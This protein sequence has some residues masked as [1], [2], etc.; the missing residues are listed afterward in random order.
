MKRWLRLV[1]LLVILAG[2][3]FGAQQWIARRPAAQVQS[4][5]APARPAPAVRTAVVDP[6]QLI[7]EDIFPADVRASAT[8][9]ITS[10]IAGR[11]GAVLIKEGSVVGAGSLLA[12]IEDPEMVLAVKQAE[13]AVAV[14]RA[15][16][17]QL[18]A[19]PRSPEVA[20]VEAQIAQQ[21]TALS[22]AERDLARTQQLFSEGLVA[23]AAVDRAQTDVE[24]ARA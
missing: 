8:V 7:E 23:R 21:E 19:G 14:Q 18:K 20:Q 22:Q 17:A 24:L 3:V 10:R 2:L 1:I 13:A 5:P 9:D 4:G 12:R 6:I 15:R 16:L 11:L